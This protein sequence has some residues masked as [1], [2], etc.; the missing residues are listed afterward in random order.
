MKVEFDLSFGKSLD[1]LKDNKIKER[2]LKAIIKFE[3]AKDLS[4]L[5][6]IKEMKG[7]PGFYRLRLGDYRLG[8][9]LISSD[10]ILLILVLHRKDIYKR[11]P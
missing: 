10:K 4:D 1:K 7:H 8:F 3:Q 5:S 2:I 11:F 6:S 9:E